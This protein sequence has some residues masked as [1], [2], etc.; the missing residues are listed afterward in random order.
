MGRGDLPASQALGSVDILKRS[1]RCLDNGPKG[2]KNDTVCKRT[3]STSYERH[4]AHSNVAIIILLKM[5]NMN[6]MI[7]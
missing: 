7:G 5:F 3:R 4:H 1:S 6:V 2:N